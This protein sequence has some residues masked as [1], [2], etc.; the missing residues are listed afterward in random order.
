ML[1]VVITALCVMVV[2]GS[3][4]AFFLMRETKRLHAFDKRLA[5]S[6]R[7][8]LKLSPAPSSVELDND[9]TGNLLSGLILATVRAVSVL[10]PFGAKEREKLAK[11]LSSAGFRHNDALAI[12]LSVKFVI[13]VILGAIISFFAAGSTLVGQYPIVV[14]FVFL[15]GAI[16]GGMIPEVTLRARCSARDRRMSEALPNGLDLLVM[17]L[18]SGLTFE[19]SLLTTSQEL[20]VIEPGL[21]REFQAM[22][23]ELRLGS[24]HRIVLADFRQRTSVEGLRDMATTLLQSERYGTP[25]TQAMRNIADGERVQRAAR[26]EEQ[27]QRLPVLMTLPMMLFVLPGTMLLMGGPAFLQAIQTMQ[28]LGGGL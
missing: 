1:Y 7:E 11:M 13:A 21:S 2:S 8:A 9:A 16:T 19:R 17:C 27:A 22:E 4:L 23:A 18:E 20:A 25:L 14:G 24:D 12:Y 6:R 15:V 5:V 10:A 3:I 26:I 28:S